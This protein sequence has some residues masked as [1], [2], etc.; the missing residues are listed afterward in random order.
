MHLPE[1][2]IA[3][4]MQFQPLLSAPSYRKMLELVVGT[5]VVAVIALLPLHLKC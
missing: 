5:L 3:I 1:P 4:L 2:I